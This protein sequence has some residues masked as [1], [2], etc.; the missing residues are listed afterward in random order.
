MNE[1]GL[2]EKDWIGNYA[3]ETDLKGDEKFGKM[4]GM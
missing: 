4:K 1:C 3:T 2:R